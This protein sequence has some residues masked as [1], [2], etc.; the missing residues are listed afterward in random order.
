MSLPKRFKA[1][2]KKFL[3]VPDPT[4]HSLN[5][6]LRRPLTLQEEVARALATQRLI[7]GLERPGYESFEE[8]NDFEI[9]DDPDDP[10]TPWEEHYHGQIE[11]HVAMERSLYEPDKSQKGLRKR[12]EDPRRD[13][14]PYSGPNRNSV[15]DS[16]ERVAREDAP[17]HVR[18]K[19]RN[20]QEVSD[21]SQTESD[22]VHST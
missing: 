10:A 15:R 11:E 22:T 4:P 13:K 6:K 1:A 12:R 3:E 7:E 18:S 21:G 20:V 9:P 5:V 2:W 14:K 16:D 19:K 8:A 17:N